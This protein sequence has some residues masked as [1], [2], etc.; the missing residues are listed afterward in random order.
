MLVIPAYWTL[1]TAISNAN[2]TFPSAYVGGSLSLD[3]HYA[4]NDPNVYANQRLLA[5]LQSNTQDVKYLVAV[6]SSTQGV[7]LVLTSERPVLYIGGFGGLDPVIDVNGLKELVAKGDLRYVL[8]APFFRRPS[9]TGRGDPEILDW[10]KTSCLVVTDFSK[11]IVYT[12]R[13][14]QQTALTSQN[15]NNN[16]IVSGPRNDYLTLYLCP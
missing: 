7:P 2:Q 16:S 13:P 3:S 6:P 15:Q 10:L 11:V 8:Y 12:R 5:Y 1:M 9:S 14:R 4:A